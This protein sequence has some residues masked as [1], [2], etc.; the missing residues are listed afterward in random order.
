[1]NILKGANCKEQRIGTSDHLL[2]TFILAPNI[3]WHLF[4]QVPQHFEPQNSTISTCNLPILPRVF[5]LEEFNRFKPLQEKILRSKIFKQN[6][7]FVR[8][9]LVSFYA[10]YSDHNYFPESQINSSY[11]CW[12]YVILKKATHRNRGFQIG[13]NNLTHQQ[14][15]ST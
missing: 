12:V 1:M 13:M 5:S 6:A 7:R 8:I 11:R 14:H 15:G 3:L 4:P 2:S 10:A 9:L